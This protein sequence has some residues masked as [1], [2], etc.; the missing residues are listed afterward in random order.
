M[1]DNEIFKSIFND[2]DTK[3]SICYLF[4]ETTCAWPRLQELCALPYNDLPKSKW[5][6]K[7][8]L[9]RLL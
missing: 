6:W 4:I 5:R 9:S 8:Y 2:S 1:K 3:Y 7:C